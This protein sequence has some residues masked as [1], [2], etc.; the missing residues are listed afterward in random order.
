MHVYVH[1]S[2]STRGR[3]RTHY[4]LTLFGEGRYASGD[5][6]RVEVEQRLSGLRKV[7]FRRQQRGALFVVVPANRVNA[8]RRM[9]I[10]SIATE[11]KNSRETTPPYITAQTIYTTHM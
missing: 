6:A 10:S 11:A 1:L 2:V 3:A 7:V 4:R 5:V 8:W 9:R